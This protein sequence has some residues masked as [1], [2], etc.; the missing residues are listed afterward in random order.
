VSDF[1]SRW[2]FLLDRDSFFSGYFFAFDRGISLD[3][4]LFV[5]AKKWFR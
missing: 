1:F 3:V 5:W 2:F 4:L